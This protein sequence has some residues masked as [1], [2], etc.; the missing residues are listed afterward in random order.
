MA[1]DDYKPDVP[2]SALAIPNAQEARKL[3]RRMAGDHEPDRC[4]F[5]CVM[6]GWNNT[7]H[8]DKDELEALGGDVTSYTGPCG[9]CSSMTLVPHD[10]IEQGSFKSVHEMATANR[11]KEYGEAADVFI[12]KVTARVMS[13]V[14][15]G[16]TLSPDPV[17][18]AAS[19]KTTRDDLPDA[20]D[21]DVSDMKA[22]KG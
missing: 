16:S 7:L 15:P 18:E 14:V 9:G 19:G 21:M 6:C 10:S 3:V 20:G 17:P 12:D 2:R 8:F 13:G 1:D 5:H 22:R 11:K 4:R